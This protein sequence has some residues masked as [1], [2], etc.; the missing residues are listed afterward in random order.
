MLKL[1]STS[2][3][4]GQQSYHGAKCIQ[5]YLYL[6]NLVIEMRL[7]IDRPHL[8]HSLLHGTGTGAYVI[9][10]FILFSGGWFDISICLSI[11][12]LSRLHTHANENAFKLK[13]LV[14]LVTI[15]L[16]E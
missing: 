16:R 14:V 10:Y 12:F 7:N 13:S 9:L 6:I 5:L 1:E 3:R 4:P 8:L 2:Q 11:A 15:C